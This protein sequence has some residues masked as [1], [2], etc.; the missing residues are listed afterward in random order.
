M[1]CGA[2]EQGKAQLLFFDWQGFFLM[3][4]VGD[5][6]VQQLA[7]ARTACAVFATIRETDAGADGGV[8]NGLALVAAELATARLNS[9]LK[10]HTIL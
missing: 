2:A 8:E 4:A 7:F 6:A 9:Y 5:V 1:W 10:T 3:G